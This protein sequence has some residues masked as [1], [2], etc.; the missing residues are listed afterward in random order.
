M[1]AEQ[2]G[3]D[4]EAFGQVGFGSTRQELG[5]EVGQE[6]G[7]RAG[8]SRRGGS[9]VEQESRANVQRIV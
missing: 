4:V 8:P 3:E 7:A 9:R 6:R 5:R 2:K 1:W